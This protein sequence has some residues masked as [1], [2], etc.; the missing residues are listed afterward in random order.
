MIM[1]LDIR[2]MNITAVILSASVCMVVLIVVISLVVYKPI[3]SIARIIVQ[4]ETAHNNEITLRANVISRLQ[5]NFFTLDLAKVRDAFELAPWVRKATVRRE[6]PNR[7]LVKLEEHR[8]AGLWGESN[9]SKL[10]NTFGEIFNANHDD[11]NDVTL[12]LLIGPDGQGLQV[13]Q[14]YRSLKQILKPLDLTIEELS[15]TG[16]GAWRM[17]LESGAVFE[18]GRG[19]VQE[20]SSRV[21]TFMQ[22]YAR[23]LST[24][25]RSGLDR[26][27]SVDLRHSGG[28][29][30]RLRGVTT[31]ITAALSDKK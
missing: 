22:T 1:P 4:G 19:S 23:V 27:E 7:I 14:T 31:T 13:L 6:F 20:L 9:E 24:Y 29:A 16:R 30:I 5:G 11:L 21:Q 25:Q 10:M 8:S 12:P 18:M 2:L 17:K 26:V 28:Y 15:L 3:F